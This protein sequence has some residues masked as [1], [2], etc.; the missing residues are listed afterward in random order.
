MTTQPGAVLNTQGFGSRPENVEVPV[1]AVFD[2]TTTDNNYPVGK[3]WIN[4][5]ANDTWELTSL[6]S[7]G[8]VLAAH[9]INTG[10]GAS[11]L[12]TLTGNSGGAISPVGGN[13]NLS[14]GPLANFVGAGNTLTLTPT[15]GGYPISP[16]VV[17][18][19][20]KAGYQTIQ[21]A[22]NAIG[23]GGSGQIWLLGSNL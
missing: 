15:T 21:S 14:G 22:L 3:R 18:P 5:A 17:G 12:A 6:T 7:V 2:P 10:G 4:T 11:Q 20:G 16:Y 23:P 19:V 8:G 1:I 13:I 9:W